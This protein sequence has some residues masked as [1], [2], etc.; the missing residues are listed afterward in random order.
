MI[1]LNVFL[2]RESY[3]DA[4]LDETH[5]IVGRFID[6]IPYLLTKRI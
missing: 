3:R 2:C 6:E 4:K 1:S 5:F